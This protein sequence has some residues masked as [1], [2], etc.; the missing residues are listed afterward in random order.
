MG[1]EFETHQAKKTPIYQLGKNVLFLGVPSS[2]STNSRKCSL[3]NLIPIIFLSI[4]ENKC[5]FSIQILGLEEDMNR[6]KII[7]VAG[8]KGKVLFIV[9]HIFINHFVI[10]HN[11]CKIILHFA[12][13]FKKG[14]LFIILWWILFIS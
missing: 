6:L 7:H 14:L 5:T 13:R 12:S 8:T 11:C 4:L 9:C 3:N 1:C 10:C 2:S